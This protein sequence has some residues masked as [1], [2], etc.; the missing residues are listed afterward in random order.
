MENIA[1]NKVKKIYVSLRKIH[2]ASVKVRVFVD[3]ASASAFR[4]LPLLPSSASACINKQTPLSF[5][6]KNPSLSSSSTSAF[7]HNSAQFFK[8]FS[9]QSVTLMATTGNKNI[10]AKLVCF[11][12]SVQKAPFF[13]AFFLF[14]FIQLCDSDL[15]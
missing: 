6:P 12:S 3:L 11:S 2:G 13:L 1:I 10:N 9:L 4:I 7:S 14:N 15:S 5:N 8:Y